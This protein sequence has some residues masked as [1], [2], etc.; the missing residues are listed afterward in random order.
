MLWAALRNCVA[1]SGCI[2]WRGR[3]RGIAVHIPPTTRARRQR[4]KIGLA[5]RK[6]PY[7]IDRNFPPAFALLSMEPGTSLFER[8]RN[9]AQLYFHCT[10]MQGVMIDRYG[11]AVGNLAEARER[12]ALVV[13]SLIMAPSLED[14]RGWVRHVSDDIGDEIFAVSFA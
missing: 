14:W 6:S 10:G 7:G 13:R 11:T 5:L 8:R 4:N 12:A 3:Q 9:L 2:A 1:I